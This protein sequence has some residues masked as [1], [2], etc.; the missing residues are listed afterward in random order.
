MNHVQG[1][2][3]REPLWKKALVFGITPLLG[4]SY[5]LWRASQFPQGIRMRDW[6]IAAFFLLFILGT[7]AVGFHLGKKYKEK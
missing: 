1:S 4:V 2:S 5:Y 3:R 7:T 6:L